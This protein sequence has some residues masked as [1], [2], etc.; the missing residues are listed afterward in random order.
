MSYWTGYRVYSY[1]SDVINHPDIMCGVHR[2]NIKTW[3]YLVYEKISKIFSKNF[4]ESKR[5][6]GIPNPPPS[7][8]WPFHIHL[9]KPHLFTLLNPPIRPP[10][11]PRFR[12]PS[13]QSPNW[14]PFE[15]RQH[16][17]WS[18]TPGYIVWRGVRKKS[19]I[20][21]GI[22]REGPPL[23]TPK[24]GFPFPMTVLPPYPPWLLPPNRCY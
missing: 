8:T 18:K 12:K 16:P 2:E 17:V 14:A 11:S 24:T 6:S 22:S 20:H 13:K 15:I 1:F 7:P 10:A 3:K 23:F 9:Q 4:I 5:M 19:Q 21:A